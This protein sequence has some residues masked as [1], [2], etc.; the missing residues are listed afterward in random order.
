MSK[1]RYR[2]WSYVKNVI[3]AY[4][5]L[6]QILREPIHTP[7]TAKYSSAPTK[8]AAGRAME[9]AAV[10]RLSGRDVAEYEA[11]LA[12]ISETARMDTGEVRL[13][14]IDLVYWKQSHTLAGA[15]MKVGYSYRRTRDFHQ[16]FFYQVAENLGLLEKMGS[17]SQKKGVS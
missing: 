12:A 17:K 5:E 14:I 11:V 1:P 3:R 7:V 10:K 13:T 4:P 2:W 16:Q 9:R 6:E 8:T 15:G